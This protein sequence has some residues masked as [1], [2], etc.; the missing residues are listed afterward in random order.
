MRKLTIALLLLLAIPAFARR[1]HPAPNPPLFH[2][3]GS[4]L[5]QNAEA[6]RLGLLRIPNDRCLAEIVAD[7][8]LVPLPT[9]IALKS[10]VRRRFGFL[11]PVAA[12]Q[13]AELAQDYYSAFKVPLI[14][15]SAVRPVTYQRRLIR[16][17]HS[18]A[19]VSGPTASVHSTGIAFDISRRHMNRNQQRWMEW[20]LWY[21]MQTGKVIVEE[22]RACFHVVATDGS[23]T[24]LESVTEKAREAPPLGVGS[25][26]LPWYE[27]SL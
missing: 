8:S 7:G 25:I 9:S 19:P 4:L 21:L 5:A 22:E 16:W 2:T 24:E 26:K 10:A 1:H 20:R 3:A 18:A 23:E 14:V 13:L 12:E 11:R 15:S 17:N 27:G 6:D